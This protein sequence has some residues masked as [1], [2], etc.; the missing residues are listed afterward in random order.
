MGERGKWVLF[1]LGI[2]LFG[3]AAAYGDRALVRLSLA[4]LLSVLYFAGLI[5]MLGWWWSENRFRHII[6]AHNRRQ[7]QQF[8][9]FQRQADAQ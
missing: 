7:E 9:R 8:E 5:F 4:E 1:F 2:G 3:H 6:D